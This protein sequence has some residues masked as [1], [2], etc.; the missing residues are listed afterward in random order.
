M[1]GLCGTPTLVAPLLRVRACVCVCARAAPR[2]HECHVP[3]CP[4]L[5]VCHSLP[6]AFPT[7]TTVLLGT[8]GGP[9]IHLDLTPA[10]YLQPQDGM[11]CLGLTPAADSGGTIMGDVGMMA[12]TSVFD[13]VNGQVGFGPVS[14]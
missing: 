12:F 11:Y 8:G 1:V 2:M 5:D 9:D 14:C 7:L 6:G 13:R 4:P 10:Y 3:A